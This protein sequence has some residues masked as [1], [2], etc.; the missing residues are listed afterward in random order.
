MLNQDKIKDYKIDIDLVSDLIK[1]INSNL[2]FFT[3]NEVIAN[4]KKN[5]DSVIPIDLIKASFA[6][7]EKK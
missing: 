6:E 5:S 2:N 1:E 3:S 4:K 7:I